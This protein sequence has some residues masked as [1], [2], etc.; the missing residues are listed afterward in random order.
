MLS[1]QRRFDLSKLGVGMPV[2]TCQHF[3]HLTCKLRRRWAF[4]NLGKQFLD[5]TRAFGR[6]KTELRCMTAN[7]VANLRAPL[8]QAVAHA[9]QHLQGLLIERLGGYKNGGTTGFGCGTLF[10][11]TPSGT[12]TTIYNFQ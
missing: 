1:H 6:N 3:E 9:H 7:G 8:H 12:F 4:F 11:I 2:L 10:K 5:A